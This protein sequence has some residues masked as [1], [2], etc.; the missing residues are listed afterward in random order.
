MSKDDVLSFVESKHQTRVF[1]LNLSDWPE[2]THVHLLTGEDVDNYM[3]YLGD[4]SMPSQKQSAYWILVC[5][6]K[7]DGSP[8][9]HPEKGKGGVPVFSDA[10]V[11]RI[12]KLPRNV[13]ARTADRI[14]DINA[15]TEDS[16]DDAEKN[17]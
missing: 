12:L 7:P 3:K 14:T 4:V 11:E 6:C 16:M 17:S 2:D 1:P 10:D 9:F 15:M 13:I 8:I 5:L